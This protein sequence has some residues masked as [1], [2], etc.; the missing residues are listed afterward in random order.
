MNNAKEKR[1]K[2]KEKR[3]KRKEKREKKR[4]ARAVVMRGLIYEIL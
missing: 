2:R 3:E 4:G 1:E